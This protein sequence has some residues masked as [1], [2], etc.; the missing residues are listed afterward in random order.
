[1]KP[2][3][4]I[5]EDESVVALDI[6]HRLRHLGYDIVAVAAKAEVAV[7]Q[8]QSLR[9]DLVLM[10]IQLRGELDGIDAAEAIYS[11]LDIPVVFLT[12][13]ADE[14]TL[15]RA[16]NVT[17]Y[18][19]LMKPLQEQE[20]HT[21]ISTA[22]YR[23]EIERKLKESERRLH[24]TLHS[25]GD[26][27]I[28][29]DTQGFIQFM[30]PVASRLTGWEAQEVL[31]KH[32]RGVFQVV[33]SKRE[34]LISNIDAV[35]ATERVVEPTYQM[36]LY[37]REGE[38]TPIEQTTT[39]IKDE[40]GRFL[41]VVIIFRDVSERLRLEQTI[42]DYTLELQAR[43]EELD[44]FAH[45]AAHDLQN[46]LAPI[47]GLIEMLESDLTHIPEE[48]ALTYIHAIHKGG[49]KMQNVIDELIILSQVRKVDVQLVPI[50]MGAIVLEAIER[51]HHMIED[52][53]VDVQ[54]PESWPI[55]MGYGPWIEEVWVNYISNA[56]KYGGAPPHL[57]LGATAEANGW[58]RFWIR[59]NGQGL[60]AEQQA[61]IFTPF[62]QLHQVSARGSG[63]GL[64]IVRRIIEKLGGQI[65]LE[66]TIG[67][68]SVF[69]FTL[70]LVNVQ[71]LT[72]E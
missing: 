45:T 66:S 69:S 63:L 67:E 1:M 37:H 26:G 30:N 5:V 59:D 72:P 36:F 55:V 35:L 47:L 32:I 25:I 46:P 10:D 3:L 50:N 53:S 57:V 19:Y 29:T 6:Q 33:R 4:M 42:R 51:L 64:S 71:G 31:G 54:L 44:A 23:H 41:G 28:A 62:T 65:G 56:I 7:R 22:L 27:V 17:P 9:P 18:G 61:Q 13:F 58:V 48:E 43:N 20:L 2:R 12:A 24:T 14:A 15:Q 34:P 40:N 52:C 68:G 49:R 21:T 39:S 38:S 60:T 11:H 8:A 70:S 16:K